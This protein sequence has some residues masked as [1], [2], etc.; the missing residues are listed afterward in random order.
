MPN[1]KNLAPIVLFVY[2]RPEHTQ[3]SLNSLMQNELADQSMLFIYADGPEEKASKQD[4]KKI[5]EVRKIIR[6][7]QWCKNVN[8]IESDKNKGLADS[9]IDGVS[10]IVNKFGKIIVLED[11][12]VLA[13]GFLKYMNDALEL[14]K[15]EEK[16]MHISG[17]MFPVKDKLPETFFYTPASCWGWGTWTKAW[18]S[19]NPSAEYL[20]AKINE[21]GNINRFNVE[22]SY[23]FYGTLQE[24]TQ[25]AITSW[26]VRWYA[27]V[28]LQDGLSLHP[29][30]SL[31]RNIGHDGSGV[32]CETNYIF[33]KQPIVEKIKVF[34]IPLKESEE[35]R[36]AMKDF[37]NSI[38]SPTLLKRIKEKVKIVFNIN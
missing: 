35:A 16:V 27:S 22:N 26:A 3:K 32:H 19:F 29:A 34:L 17:Y 1:L 18:K 15:D 12:L 5:H 11:D 20:L 9:I 24:N 2:N 30:R 13:S 23:D 10:E 8:I 4:L 33:N 31:V 25:R 6:E 28:F 14:Y 37:I 7:E 38:Y 21:Q 36:K